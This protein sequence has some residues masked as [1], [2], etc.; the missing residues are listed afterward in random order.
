VPTGAL[1]TG[2][3]QKSLADVP[4]QR[5]GTVETD[6]I[7]LLNLNDSCAAAAGDPE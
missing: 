4:P 5:L 2:V 3:V 7:D 1:L 6:S